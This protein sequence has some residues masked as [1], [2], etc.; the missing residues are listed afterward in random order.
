PDVPRIS[1]DDTWAWLD[2]GVVP[3]PSEK[4][5]TTSNAQRL[6]KLYN[7]YGASFVCSHTETK[8]AVHFVLTNKELE[9]LFD[10]VQQLLKKEVLMQLDNHATDVY[11]VSYLPS[12]NYRL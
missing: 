10:T 6:V 7:K 1:S 9:A 2:G 11:T 8:D 12:L 4:E 3:V 5:T